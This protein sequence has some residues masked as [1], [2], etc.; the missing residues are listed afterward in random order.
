M[1][2]KMR[3]GTRL[4]LFLAKHP[5][6]KPYIPELL[7][8]YRTCQAKKLGSRTVDLDEAYAHV[9]SSLCSR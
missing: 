5:W 1:K 8:V 7:A 6:L 4:E 2:L 9:F 3:F